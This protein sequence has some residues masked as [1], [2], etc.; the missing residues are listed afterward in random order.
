MLQELL[1]SLE[2]GQICTKTIFYEGPN[3][4]EGSLLHGGSILHRSKNTKKNNNRQIN[5]KKRKKV[6]DRG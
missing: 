6:T 2:M 1:F 3:M 5:K 4:H